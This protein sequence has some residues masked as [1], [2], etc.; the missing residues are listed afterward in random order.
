LCE[1]LE[2][3]KR[4]EEMNIRHTV[5]FFGSA[6]VRPENNG[7]AFLDKSYW[8]AEEFAYLLAEWSKTLPEDIDFTICTGG[9]P[10]IMKRRIAAR[11]AP[12]RGISV[13]IFHF[14]SNSIRT[15]IYLPI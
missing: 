10:G 6:R 2:P 3:E 15:T 11:R 14:L 5:V 12:E 8:A 13:S 1:Y 4:L 7:D 9:G